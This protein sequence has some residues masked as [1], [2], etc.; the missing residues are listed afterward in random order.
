MLV[1]HCGLLLT[2]TLICFTIPRKPQL[3]LS[4]DQE[5]PIDRER[6]VSVLSRYTLSWANPLLSDA[7]RMGGLELD[8]LSHLRAQM[9][10]SALVLHF[11]SFKTARLWK[12]ITRAH[13]PAL[14]TQWMLTVCWAFFTLAPQYF[15]YKLL[16]TLEDDS[17]RP[18]ARAGLWLGLLGL[19][20]FV[21]PWTET[22]ALWIGWCHIALP[23]YIQL[24][25]LIVEKSIWKKDVKGTGADRA[26]PEPGS[27]QEGDKDKDTK[28]EDN[29]FP[30]KEV[31]VDRNDA[32]DEINLI[33]VD[34]QRLT[35]FLSY[36][37]HYTTAQ[38]NLMQTRD[39]KVGSLT[40]C[41]QGVRQIKFDALEPQ[42]KKLLGAV[43]STELEKQRRS[44]LMETL[45][46][47]CWIT[48][49]YL[50]AAVTLASISIYEDGLTPSVAFTALAVFQRLETT[51]NL[52]PGL[53]T[54]LFDAWVSFDRL[55]SYLSSAE[56]VDY[57]ISDDLIAF[58]SA[59]INWP[60][61][62]EASVHTKL[63]S[64]ELKFPNHALSI[65]AGPTGVGKSLLLSAIVGEAEITSG[66]VRRP[67]PR[68]TPFAESSQTG[69][70]AWIIPKTMALVAQTP[71]IENA[72]VRDNVL[73]GLP[74]AD[75]RYMQVLH[76]CALLQD[77]ATMEDGD[78]TEIGLHGIGI[79]G[80][81]RIRLSLARAL[82]SRA[83]ILVIDD[84]FSAVDI[85]VARHILDH[86]LTGEL[87]EGRTCILA[88]HNLQLCLSK[89]AFVVM[90]NE[91]TVEY[92]GLSTEIPQNVHPLS[93]E[94]KDK[95]GAD[96]TVTSADQHSKSIEPHS[97]KEVG[98]LSISKSSPSELNPTVN[99]DAE[100]SI[101]MA[102][103]KIGDYSNNHLSIPRKLVQKEGREHGR[104]KTNVYKAYFGA[105]SSCPWIYWLIGII[106]LT[107]FEVAV[108]G[109]NLWVKSW[110][111]QSRWS[112]MNNGFDVLNQG[113]MSKNGLPGMQ[114]MIS[115]APKYH[116]VDAAINHSSNTYRIIGC[117]LISL[118][119]S[120]LG[121]LK[122]L[123]VFLGSLRASRQFFKSM[124]GAVLH[125]PLRW[126]DT[127]P[128][129]R[130]MNRFTTDFNV[131]DSVLAAHLVLFVHSG[132]QLTGILVAGGLISPLLFIFFVPLLGICVLYA[133]IYLAGARDAK[134][135]QSVNKSPVL[136][137]IDSVLSGLST[138][139]AWGHCN[140]FVDRIYAK[141][142]AHARCVWHLWLFNR[143]LGIRFA[144]IGAMFTTVVAAFAVYSPVVSVPLAGLALTFSLDFTQ[145]IFWV[146]RRYADVEMDMN[147]LER[148][149]EYC[150]LPTESSEG[151]SPP[152]HWPSRG[153]IEVSDLV[154][155]YAADLRP[156][157]QGVTFS[158][159]PNNRI[160][161]VGRTGAGKSS[162]ILAL[163]RFLEARGGSIV[164]DGIDIATLTLK[165]LRER[166]AVIPQQPV[167]W[168]GTVRSNLDPF[169][170]YADEKLREVLERVQLNGRLMCS[171]VSDNCEEV[172]PGHYFTLS[173]P[174]AEGGA[175][176]SL[177]QRQ[178]LS[179]ARVLLTRPKILIMDEA[180]SAVD[181]DR[182]NIVQQSIRNDLQDSTLIVV[183]HR[184]ST[185]ID[186]DQIIVFEEGK[187]AEIGSPK[188]LW[189]QKGVFS[190]MV[191]QSK[192]NGLL[193]KLADED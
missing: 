159:E 70:I 37:S 62:D 88:T 10:T 21:Q 77:L 128:R 84:I 34:A 158:C 191:R 119:A 86:A 69:S 80:G 188:D 110:S 139:R 111:E 117:I 121:T 132:L 83:E 164:I 167:L 30:T 79:S 129:G 120:F 89:A 7:M 146:L 94:E 156:V 161:I 170:D 153:R 124:M 55:E 72:T 187:V 160:G 108:I 52:A 178:L 23:I 82:Y 155:E 186:L 113:A 90:L 177:G 147:S 175:N 6:N 180:T 48:G 109:R 18:G 107:G 131:I 162:L 45:V 144:V 143:W 123:W 91:R 39:N 27:V 76:A 16:G 60:S 20:Q 78:M 28:M 31:P 87:T 74:L 36:N 126:L 51:L 14:A 46:N 115:L 103:K 42:W 44:F 8:S 134:R 71:W 11:K 182:D 97:W 102:G 24:S 17:G 179:L 9:T 106:L 29:D 56:W 112:S 184:L 193:G 58:E 163:F 33:T 125:A 189:K 192:E 41:I 136:E 61:R 137:Q 47:G 95:G 172:E 1:A 38:R 173:T 13:V 92:A 93:T 63:H 100:S 154:V 68:L 141:I 157:L 171:D 67:K 35:D 25:G 169:N 98:T 118:L 151:N 53:V 64:L 65:V 5:K 49:S 96:G 176:I 150:S 3:F 22:W 116:R 40:E 99:A 174:I 190:Q 133:R 43:R 165:D 135:L 114:M 127:V 75:S 57:T 26:T 168:L 145:S 140:T 12:H 15:L 50:F 2:S 73:F 19:S 85:H 183:A 152:A 32:Q 66:Y 101:R 185:I 138:I 130:I 4:G 105:T 149:V 148:V 142:D 104:V 181:L 166:M 54:D 81:Q 122:F 59:S